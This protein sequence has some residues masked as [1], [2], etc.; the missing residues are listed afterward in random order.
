M[1]AIAAATVLAM[2]LAASPP[3]SAFDDGAIGRLELAQAESWN[4]H[5]AR[6]Y[7]ALFT[8][9]ADVVNVLGWHWKG[10]REL[11]MKL[12]AAFAGPFRSSAL[13][14]DGRRRGCWGGRIS[15]S[16]TCDGQ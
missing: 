4:N 15:P 3:V 16:L 9:D 6:A 1:W 10:R 14:I 7:A 2:A 12:A 8:P 5:D 13:R 11:A